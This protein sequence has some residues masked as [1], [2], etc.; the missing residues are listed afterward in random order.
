MPRKAPQ[1]AVDAAR[2]LLVQYYASKRRRHTFDSIARR[3]GL[4]R[5]TVARLAKDVREALPTVATLERRMKMLEDRV[6]R[7]EA[8][9]AKRAA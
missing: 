9:L 3:S 1:E 5:A 4:S 7:L 2:A 6:A 8:R